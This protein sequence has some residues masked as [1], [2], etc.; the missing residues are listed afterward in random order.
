MTINIMGKEDR[1]A[2]FW[3]RLLP[4]ILLQKKLTMIPHNQQH[5]SILATGAAITL[6]AAVLY[7]INWPRLIFRFV[8]SILAPT[9]E[10]LW[11]SDDERIS[12]Q[13]RGMAWVLLAGP[14]PPHDIQ[15]IRTMMKYFWPNAWPREGKDIQVEILPTPRKGSQTLLIWPQPIKRNNTAVIHLHGG[16]MVAGTTGTERGFAVELARRLKVPVLSIDYRLV[17]ENLVQDAVQ[18]VV[19]AYQYFLKNYPQFTKLSFLGGSAG[20][21]H[22]LLAALK[23]KELGVKPSPTSLV[24]S[25]PGPGMEFLPPEDVYNS[26]NSLKENAPFDGYMAGEFYQYVTSIVYQA[27]ENKDCFR[28]QLADLEGLPPCLVTMGSYEVILDGARKLVQCLRDAKVKVDSIE[29]WKCQHC[30]FAFFEIA[31]ESS[32][33]LDELIGWI[34]KSWE[35]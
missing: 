19:D 2:I 10:R 13:A 26:W 34:E 22:S 35:T 4:S 17:P 29:Y 30:H 18:D 5:S 27:E 23:L 11:P 12:P 25:S 32:A 3:R 31:P 6:G 24:L 8:F 33:A 16:G 20:A 28:K 21:G 7:Q 1:S 9:K 14:P 15:P